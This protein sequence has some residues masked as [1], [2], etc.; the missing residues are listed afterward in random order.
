[1]LYNKIDSVKDGPTLLYPKSSLTADD[2]AI[3]IN[4]WDQQSI[5]VGNYYA[6]ARGIPQERIIHFNMS[7]S[8]RIYSEEFNAIFNYVNSVVPASV[9]AYAIS[10]TWPYAVN[11]MSITSAF[12]LGYNE[13]LYCGVVDWNIGDC[14]GTAPVPYYDSTSVAP[15]SDFGIRIAMSIGMFCI[16]Y[17]CLY[18]I[19]IIH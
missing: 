14:T 17:L 10:W 6:Q 9:Q 2:F 3:L 4:D 18:I 1:M 7:T 13:T 12:A 11:C 15:Y 5:E 8:E 16:Y 19:L